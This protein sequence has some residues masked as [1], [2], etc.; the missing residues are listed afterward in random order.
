MIR[1]ALLTLLSLPLLALATDKP[2]MEG[3]W[4]VKKLDVNGKAFPPIAEGKEMVWKV[5][6]K[7]I[8][9]ELDGKAILSL[10]F[11]TDT[12]TMPKI[13]DMEVVQGNNDAPKGQKL[14]AIYKLDG[15]DLTICVSTPETTDRPTQFET[16]EGSNTAL[17]VLKRAK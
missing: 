5:S 3:T 7:T 8:A 14:P 16:K 15:D 12:T 6:E 11:T 4:T 1:F 10:N 9:I 17:I 2:T 13:L